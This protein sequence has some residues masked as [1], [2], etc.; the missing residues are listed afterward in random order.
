MPIKAK[1][2]Q[3]IPAHNNIIAPIIQ[4]TR[5]FLDVLGLMEILGG[6]VDYNQINCLSQGTVW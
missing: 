5:P 4:A 6:N 3:E 2:M 1:I